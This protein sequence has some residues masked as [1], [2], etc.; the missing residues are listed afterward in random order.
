MSMEN[1][2]NWMS[3]PVPKDEVIIWF[4]VHNMN[5]EKIELFGD[6]FK[7][8]NQIVLDTYMGDDIKET[9]ISMTLEDKELHF[10][11]C[12]K[13]TIDDFMKEGIEIISKRTSKR[14]G[15]SEV[16]ILFLFLSLISNFKQ[17][18][19]RNLLK[20]TKEN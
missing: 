14:F 11:W 18:L 13:K 8:L 20:K 4:N 9:K 6:I 12:W 17:F 1:F 5:Y 15:V 7:S 3:K 2:F 19:L 16:I 10:E